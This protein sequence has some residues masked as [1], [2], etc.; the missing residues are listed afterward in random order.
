M[1]LIWATNLNLNGV[2]FNFTAFPFPNVKIK[3]LLDMVYLETFQYNN[4]LKFLTFSPFKN[5]SKNK[6]FFALQPGSAALEQ[7]KFS[8]FCLVMPSLIWQ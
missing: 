6:R 4:F 8:L 7:P 1:K 5:T 2:Y 3:A